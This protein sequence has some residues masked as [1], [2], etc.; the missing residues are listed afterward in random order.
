MA[1]TRKR[2]FSESRNRKKKIPAGTSAR[3]GYSISDAITRN[4]VSMCLSPATFLP[5]GF[6]LYKAG[7]QTIRTAAVI[8]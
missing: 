5:V 4:V 1:T 7:V 3:S 6:H 8:R 2:R